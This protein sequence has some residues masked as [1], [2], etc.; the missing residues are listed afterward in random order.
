MAAINATA[1]LP[2]LQGYA[3][4]LGRLFTGIAALMTFSF[5]YSLG[6]D[7]TIACWLIGTGLAAVTVLVSILLNFVDLAWTDN[8]PVAL[9]ILAFWG[10]C[11]AVEYF[12]HVG[13]T[14]GHRTSDVQKASLQDASYTGNANIVRDLEAKVKRLEAKHD[15]QKSME[16][17]EAYEAKITGMQGDLIWKRS[18]GCTNA[19]L[20]D[21]RAFCTRL[22]GL[23]AEMAIASDRAIVAIELKDA[24][25]ELIAAR[26]TSNTTSKGDSHVYSQ[27]AMV[28]QIA[29]GN[30]APTATA[31]QWAGIGI[32]AFISLVF[33]F[34]G[35]VCN[36]LAF[37][38]W[39]GS[40]G[41]RTQ[42]HAPE[43]SAPQAAASPAPAPTVVYWDRIVDRPIDRI[44]SQPAE[45]VERVK[46]MLIAPSGGL[47]PLK[48]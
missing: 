12:S 25:K 46:R 10:V 18:K 41:N 40:P 29:T 19:T 22:A 7:S 37:K 8:R 45:V 30:L 14:V 2:E 47:V 39:G 36:F 27:T 26:K 32:G 42:P 48:G 15:W 1:G 43:A 3:R 5:G 34:A 13:F 16:T 23:K 11:V 33:S 21:S 44:V 17:P 4:W 31:M 28:A 24:Q 20:D 6:G 35:T 38:D 9:G